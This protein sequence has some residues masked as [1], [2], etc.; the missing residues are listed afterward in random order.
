VRFFIDV[1]NK[2]KIEVLQDWIEEN[3]YSVVKEPPYDVVVVNFPLNNFPLSIPRLLREINK[4]GVKV[5][6]DAIVNHED[7]LPL[8]D[9][10]D[11]EEAIDYF[12]KAGDV[13][14][15]D[16]RNL[17]VKAM[18]HLLTYLSKFHI[19]MGELFGILD[20]DHK[21]LE[22]VDREFGNGY[23]IE[24][25]V[26]AQGITQGKLLQPF[27]PVYITTLTSIPES[28]MVVFSKSVPIYASLEK[29]DFSGGDVVVYKGEWK[30][31][32]DKFV[33]ATG[34]NADVIHTPLEEEEI[35]YGTSSF[36][37]KATVIDEG[38]SD[39]EKLAT[40]VVSLTPVASAFVFDDKEMVDK[41]FFIEENPTATSMKESKVLAVN[42]DLKSPDICERYERIIA[43]SVSDEVRRVCQSKMLLRRF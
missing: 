3:E 25:V 30:G 10:E 22:V 17:A 32:N 14:V 5:L 21:I 9:P 23:I 8:V 12:E 38:L 42:F 39:I 35:L 16:R 26:E 20:F 34:G 40:A 43:S 33:V 28:S 27:L 18:K 37:Q 19:R 4:E 36:I 13:P 15:A 6:F 2:D 24:A 11:Y 41:R 29:K 31:H 7:I 1:F